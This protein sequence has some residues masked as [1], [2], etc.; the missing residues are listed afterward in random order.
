MAAHQV[1]LL[2]QQVYPVLAVLGRVLPVVQVVAWEVRLWQMFQALRLAIPELLQAVA[3]AAQRI[4]QQVQLVGLG[5][6]GGLF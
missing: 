5:V 1:E 2:Q 4:S 6:Q 3:E